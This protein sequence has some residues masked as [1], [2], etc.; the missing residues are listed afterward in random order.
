MNIKNID[1][2]SFQNLMMSDQLYQSLLKNM[3]FSINEYYKII[4]YIKYLEQFLHYMEDNESNSVFLKSRVNIMN[5]NY[6][7]LI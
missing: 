6:S 7:F 4:N 2:C 5:F 1:F 3:K